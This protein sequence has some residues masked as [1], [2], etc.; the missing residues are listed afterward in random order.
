LEKRW[1]K[2]GFDQEGRGSVKKLLLGIIAFVLGLFMSTGAWA[3]T[4][5]DSTHGATT[6]YGGIIRPDPTEY[7]DYIGRDFR[8]TSLTATQTATHTTVVLT[9]PY[10]QSAYARGLYDVGQIGD[11]Y[12]STSGW[13][14]N[15]P[16]DHARA[17]A[18][19]ANEGWNYVVSY[20]ATTVYVLDFGSIFMSGDE[21]GRWGGFRD[22]QAYR[23]GYGS[24][25]AD[26]TAVLDF[27]LG[28]NSTLTFTF[29][30]LGNV[31]RMGYHWTMAC[32]N[33]VVEGGGTSAPEPATMLLLG[34]GL[35]ALA[36]YGRKKFKK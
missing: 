22:D 31:D 6:Y 15:S 14:V 27:S 23:G 8:V 7:N 16:A 24:V 13:T 28:D 21:N 4:I 17:D 9:G 20:L 32:G 34:S 5:D 30:N 12:I 26:A 3:L 10:F 19:A 2:V 18:F 35:L 1:K 36:G 25:Y 33:D 11:L 29:P